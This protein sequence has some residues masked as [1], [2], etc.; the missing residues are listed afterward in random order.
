MYFLLQNGLLTTDW[1]LAIPSIPGEQKKD[2]IG[3]TIGYYLA[4]SSSP[5]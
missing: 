2:F 4:S 5:I 3:G 1:D